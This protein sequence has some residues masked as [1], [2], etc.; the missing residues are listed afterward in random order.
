MQ[1][2]KMEVWEATV[3]IMVLILAHILLQSRQDDLIRLAK[4]DKKHRKFDNHKSNDPSPFV[5]RFFF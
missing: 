4:K 3:A 1:T 2:K 5:E